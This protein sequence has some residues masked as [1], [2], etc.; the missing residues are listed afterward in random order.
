M[1]SL[2]SATGGLDDQQIKN[3]RMGM[4]IVIKS[5]P[6]VIKVLNPERESSERT[7]IINDLRSTLT[8]Y[9]EREREYQDAMDSL[10]NTRIQIRDQIALQQERA[11]TDD[12][13]NN[14]A[15]DRTCSIDVDKLFQDEKVKLPKSSKNYVE[16]HPK[17][18]EFE[19]KLTI[20]LQNSIEREN[21]EDVDAMTVTQDDDG[22]VIAT[23][24]TS[25]I[26]PI[27]RKEMTDP[28]KNTLCGHTY[29]R[30]SIYQLITKHPKTKCPM[31]GCANLNPVNPNHLI[32][33]SDVL[34][35]IQRKNKKV[36]K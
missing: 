2:N 4:D 17:M 15:K 11:L 27:T 7:K 25:T 9:I 24:M 3:L 10:A 18:N 12:S 23:E 32:L 21:V 16:K 34:K 19:T 20:E 28:V 36:K 5:I 8:A 31:A 30:N 14:L 26:D 29:E 22:E 13:G 33:N 1:S 6:Q 35:V